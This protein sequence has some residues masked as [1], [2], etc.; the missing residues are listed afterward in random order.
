MSPLPSP[1][2]TAPQPTDAALER[3]ITDAANGIFAAIQGGDDEGA[4]RMLDEGARTV[5]RDFG[6]AASARYASAVPARCFSD[7]RPALS[8]AERA[9][10]SGLPKITAALARCC[11]GR[12]AWFMLETALLQ[13]WLD[14]ARLIIA[15]GRRAL[16]DSRHAPDFFAAL[17]AALS[18]PD[19]LRILSAAP[20]PPRQDVSYPAFFQGHRQAASAAL[21]VALS[22]QR[23]AILEV[24]REHFPLCLYDISKV[25]APTRAPEERGYVARAL[26]SPSPGEQ[27]EGLTAKALAFLFDHLTMDA[28]T[29]IGLAASVSARHQATTDAWQEC[30]AA[31]P[32]I[33]AVFARE[34]STQHFA[35]V[36]VRSLAGLTIQEACARMA[37]LAPLVAN[38]PRRRPRRAPAAPNAE[39]ITA[40]ATAVSDLRTLWN[41]AIA[42]ATLQAPAAAPR[43]RRRG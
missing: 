24:L 10:D 13:G 18:S 8:L 42:R 33:A 5:H 11:A 7:P 40:T 41:A 34:A 16:A 38:A 23:D 20:R 31:R 25:L 15:A 14:G 19:A 30:C 22:P 43:P 4:V 32:D 9:V 17:D 28:R 21:T 3:H 1:P 6:M 37:V 12:Q 36:L 2:T 27:G 35:H 29:F 39:P 26:R